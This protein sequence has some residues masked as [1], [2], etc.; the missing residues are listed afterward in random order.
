MCSLGPSLV[1]LNQSLF[2]QDS[3]VMVHVCEAP[4]EGISKAGSEGGNGHLWWVVPISRSDLPSTLRLR[5]C[6]SP[7]SHPRPRE[8]SLT[9]NLLK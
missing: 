8:K 3:Q 1:L 2:Q 9:L 6:P 7:T 4:V 5:G